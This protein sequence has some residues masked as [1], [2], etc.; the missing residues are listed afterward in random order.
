MKHFFIVN[1]GNIYDFH[2][3]NNETF[4][5]DIRLLCRFCFYEREISEFSVLERGWE[6]G[7]NYDIRQNFIE[8]SKNMDLCE[9]ENMKV[10]ATLVIV[11]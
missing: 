3:K 6:V 11:V 4:V 2:L 10:P 7:N 9:D 8:L 1:T 5:T